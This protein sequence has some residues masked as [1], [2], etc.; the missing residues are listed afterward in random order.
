MYGFWDAIGRTDLSEV[1]VREVRRRQ[2][3][4]AEDAKQGREYNCG[5]LEFIGMVTAQYSLLFWMLKFHVAARETA[6][7]Q[8]AMPTGL[9]KIPWQNFWQCSLGCPDLS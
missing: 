5:V 9:K 2:P 7:T 4:A 8:K 3:C 6:F 1:F